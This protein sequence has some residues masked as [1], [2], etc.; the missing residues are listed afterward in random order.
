MNFRKLQNGV[1]VYEL[2]ESV[3]LIV[4]IIVPATPPIVIRPF[5]VV[6]ERTVAVSSGFSLS[7]IA[8]VKPVRLI[9]ALDESL[10]VSV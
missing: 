6:K 3:E 1:Q 10:S 4:N 9:T 8:P 2:D 7:D 5:A